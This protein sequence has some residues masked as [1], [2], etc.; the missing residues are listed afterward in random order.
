M[1]KTPCARKCICI[2]KFEDVLLKLISKPLP[3]FI[4]LRKNFLKTNTHMHSH[5]YNTRYGGK[6][7]NCPLRSYSLLSFEFLV[8]W[9]A[10]CCLLVPVS[11]LALSTVLKGCQSYCF[12]C[13]I[14]GVPGAALK[15]QSQCAFCLFISWKHP[16]L[17][18][19]RERKKERG[20]AE[21]RKGGKGERDRWMGEGKEGG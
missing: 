3:R 6:T 10:P 8:S 11:M 17:E 14:W 15:C 12:K 7:S 4:A 9:R 16:Y 18:R 21:G 2:I 1:L 13:R 20:E 19:E 5:M